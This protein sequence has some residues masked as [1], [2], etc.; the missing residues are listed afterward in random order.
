MLVL[1]DQATPVPL[2]PYLEG[3]TVKTAWEQAGFDLFLTTDKNLSYQQN[4]SGRRIAVLVLGQQQWP[5]LRP[6]V[7]L[8]IDAVNAVTPGS[9]REVNIPH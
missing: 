3:L 6:Y 9:Y 4:L 8:V 7:R 2:R 5:D 1:F